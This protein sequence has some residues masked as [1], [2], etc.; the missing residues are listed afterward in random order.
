M[1][2]LNRPEQGA[3]VNKRKLGK[4]ASN[5]V[6]LQV[7]LPRCFVAG[8]GE[9][10]LPPLRIFFYIDALNFY[11]GALRH[12]SFRW[13]DIGAFCEAI[14]REQVRFVTDTDGLKEHPFKIEGIKIF[15]AH[16]K[17]L[18]WDPGAPARQKLYL[19]ALCAH[20]P[21][22]DIQYG[23]F[24]VHEHMAYDAESTGKR[25]K[26]IRPEEKG[27]DVNLALHMLNDAF[28]DKYDCAIMVSND[29]DLLSALTMVHEQKKMVGVA[30]PRANRSKS[31]KNNADFYLDVRSKLLA[32][33]QLPDPVPYKT[34]KILRKPKEWSAP[35][36]NL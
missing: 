6:K 10:V 18:F 20:D 29:T 11:Y 5:S 32:G 31:L 28:N 27:S 16:L 35:K 9:G 33:C 15:T 24:S 4:S 17:E 25:H 30:L 22:I 2:N 13:L 3:S 21:R 23:K 14:L 26:I 36:A 19:T 1:A 34:K 12:T 8:R 7:Q